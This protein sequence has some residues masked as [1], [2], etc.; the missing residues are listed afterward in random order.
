MKKAFIIYGGWEGH[1][2]VGTTPIAKEILEK[3]N[4]NVDLSQSLDDLLNIKTDDYD[5]IIINVS[6]SNITKEHSEALSEL[7]KNGVGFAAWHGGLGDS[8]RNHKTYQY[9]L[10]GQFVYHPAPLEYEVNITSE[11]LL[12]GMK[13]FSINSERY[14]C[15]VD[16]SVN[17]HGITTINENNKVFQMPIVWTKYHGKGRVFYSSLGHD[18]N[19]FNSNVKEILRRGFLWCISK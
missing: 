13:D 14:Y 8:S 5:L 12:K 17:V 10:G 19:D 18:R 9:I 1:D 6:L 7:I 2:P 11:D 16:P 4:I 3:E 15:H